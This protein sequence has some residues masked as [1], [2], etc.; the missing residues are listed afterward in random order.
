MEDSDQPLNAAHCLHQAVSRSP[1][2]TQEGP[3]AQLPAEAA[4]KHPVVGSWGRGGAL[5]ESDQ[6]PWN[7]PEAYADV[8]RDLPPEGV[9]PKRQ[10]VPHKYVKL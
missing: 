9:V 7:W 8:W 6:V 3:L 2:E 10:T 1:S 4:R 5:G